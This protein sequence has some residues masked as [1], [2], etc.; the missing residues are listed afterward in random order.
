[1]RLFEDQKDL[2]SQSDFAKTVGVSRN[3]VHKAIK[4]GRLN[5]SVELVDGIPM[6]WKN[7]AVKE[8]CN[9]TF[10]AKKSIKG[11]KKEASEYNFHS[12]RAK[13][14]HFEAKLK[15]LQYQKEMK[16]LVER[17]KVEGSFKEAGL[18][19]KTKLKSL[20]Q[21]ISYD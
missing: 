17:E 21:K 15:D 7:I 3:S 20:P 2:V 16:E 13:K 4:S 1:M 11:S 18:R 9:N 5:R 8:W 19:L 10:Q 12:E 14:E 6:L